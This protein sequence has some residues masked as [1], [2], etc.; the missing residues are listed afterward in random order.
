MLGPLKKPAKLA[1][2]QEILDGY[3]F[4]SNFYE[5]YYWMKWCLIH[6]LYWVYSKEILK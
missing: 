2:N 4:C 1:Y 6:S 5:N 3:Q